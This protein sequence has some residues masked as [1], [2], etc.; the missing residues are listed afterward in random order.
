MTVHYYGTADPLNELQ[1]ADCGKVFHSKYSDELLCPLCR[2]YPRKP[3]A[4]RTPRASR[5]VTVTCQDCGTSFTTRHAD[6]IR[7]GPCAMNE[8]MA[9]TEGS[10]R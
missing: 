7:C 9:S 10:S 5:D 2:K 4:V 1:C 3:R 6:M 8:L